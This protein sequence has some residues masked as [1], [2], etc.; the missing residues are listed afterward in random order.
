MFRGSILFYLILLLNEQQQQIFAHK[1]KTGFR[2]LPLGYI[3]QPPLLSLNCKDL[4]VA[5]IA[6]KPN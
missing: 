1:Y 3:Y 4:R 2:D 6:L 5:L